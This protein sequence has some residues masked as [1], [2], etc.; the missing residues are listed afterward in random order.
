MKTK[1]KNKEANISKHYKKQRYKREKFIN[2]YVNG[3]GRMVD[4][5]IIDKGHKGGVEVHSITEN[6]I[7]I[8]HNLVTGKLITKLCARE[9]QIKRY[10]ES[11]GRT[12]PP[13]YERILE[14]AR[15][16]ESLGYN[17]M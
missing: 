14:L 12:P 16:H 9:Q 17:Y 2:K 3:D 15:W 1:I 8:I 13:E 4:G 11:T 6:G 5:F 10:Y 7:I